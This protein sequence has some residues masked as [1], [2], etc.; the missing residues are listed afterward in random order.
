MSRFDDNLKKALIEYEKE[1]VESGE[2]ESKT[3]K[4]TIRRKNRRKYIQILAI[5]L[6]VFIPSA[7]IGNGNIFQ[8][9]EKNIDTGAMKDT[10]HEYKT[11]ENK[12]LESAEKGI[13][14]NLENI[15]KD[16]II[17]DQKFIE[18]INLSLETLKFEDTITNLEDIMKKYN[19]YIEYQN[20]DN[21]KDSYSG[22]NAIYKYKIPNKD[23][24]KFT[25]EIKKLDINILNNNKSLTNVTNHYNDLNR[26]LE[27]LNSKLDKLQE[28]LKKASNLSEIVELENKIME[29]ESQKKNIENDLSSLEKEINYSTIELNIQEVSKYSGTENINAGFLSRLKNSFKDAGITFLRVMENTLIGFIKILPFLIVAGII[30]GI[31]YL[32]IKKRKNS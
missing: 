11:D 18:N 2:L 9:K 25:D 28:L 27:L 10:A 12:S 22:R 8:S 1:I 23:A 24:D 30:G 21:S 32:V 5:F 29:V 13:D 7:I 4:T 20:I 31:V 14:E 16:E 15:Q 19:G 6:L 3:P 17:S 26:E